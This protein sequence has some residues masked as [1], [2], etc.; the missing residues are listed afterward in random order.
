MNVLIE[1][2]SAEL[3]IKQ[4]V[5]QKTNKE[6]CIREQSGYLKLPEFKYPQRFKFALEDDAQPYPAG[7][8]TL[9]ASCLWVNRFG[10]LKLGR[11]RLKPVQTAQQ[12]RPAP[13]TS[14]T[15]AGVRS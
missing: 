8:Y 2:E 14:A 11:V 6:Y 4:G 12:P 15:A 13:V 10:E 3:A 5:S 9:D 7:N 1:I